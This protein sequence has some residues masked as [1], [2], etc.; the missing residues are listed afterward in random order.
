[1]NEQEIDTLLDENL[2]LAFKYF[3]KV[4]EKGSSKDNGDTERIMQ[5]IEGL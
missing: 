4:T 1:M 2:E 5:L 3:N